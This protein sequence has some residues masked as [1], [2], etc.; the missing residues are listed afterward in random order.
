MRQKYER[1]R[2]RHRERLKRQCLK[3]ETHQGWDKRGLRTSL[4]PQISQWQLLHSHTQR[5]PT[6]HQTLSKR[7]NLPRKAAFLPRPA[8]RLLLSG[9]SQRGVSHP[10]PEVRMLGGMQ[11]PRGK[12]QSFPLEEK[13]ACF[14][15]TQAAPRFRLPSLGS[16]PWCC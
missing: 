5:H 3:I 8:S 6:P 15:C 13:E 9:A 14:N 12:N 7:L 2:E 4:V 1:Q 16:C 11:T 10:G